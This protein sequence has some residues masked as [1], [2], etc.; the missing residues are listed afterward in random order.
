LGKIAML[1]DATIQQSMGIR[2]HRF[3]IALALSALPLA[4][5]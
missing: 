5:Y 4:G 1:N 2:T 3:H